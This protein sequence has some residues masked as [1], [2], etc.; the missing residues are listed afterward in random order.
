[1]T[2]DDSSLLP[3]II[4]EKQFRVADRERLGSDQPCLGGTTF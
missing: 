3:Q 1:L 2:S 4:E